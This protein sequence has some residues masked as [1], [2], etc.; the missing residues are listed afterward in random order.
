MGNLVQEL[1][2]ET[3]Y[4]RGAAQA[5]GKG[6][7]TVSRTKTK[8]RCR[9][10]RAPVEDVLAGG[11]AKPTK[12]TRVIRAGRQKIHMVESAGGGERPLG[13]SSHRRKKGGQPAPAGTHSGVLKARRAPSNAVTASSGRGPPPGGVGVV[14][15]DT[16]PEQSDVCGQV[17]HSRGLASHQRESWWHSKQC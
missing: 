8:P 2:A 4:V 16:L 5:K 13:Q 14:A 10:G 9:S 12:R 1:N 11:F 15:G 17:G 7:L 6:Q 3:V